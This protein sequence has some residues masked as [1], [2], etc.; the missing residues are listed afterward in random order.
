MVC[1]D[2]LFSS[3]GAVALTDPLARHDP[4]GLAAHR[5]D[6]VGVEGAT[7]PLPCAWAALVR[8]RHI[9]RFDARQGTALP[10]A[11]AVKTGCSRER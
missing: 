3:L 5:A 11:A 7:V 4:E 1:A 8:K 2:T 10:G 9:A 6:D